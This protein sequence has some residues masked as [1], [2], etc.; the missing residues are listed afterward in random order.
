MA[1]K[2][3]KIEHHIGKSKAGRHKKMKRD[4]NRKLRRVKQTEKP[5]TKEYKGWEF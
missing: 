1:L 5:N 2:S 4:R 3:E